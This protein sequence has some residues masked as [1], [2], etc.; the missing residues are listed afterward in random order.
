[1]SYQ[2]QD[3][4]LV[5]AL[6]LTQQIKEAAERADVAA[7]TALDGQRAKLIHSFRR[8]MRSVNEADRALLRQITELNDR[9]IGMLEHHQRSKGRELDLAA[10]GRRAVAAYA[11]ARGR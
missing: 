6:R 11:Q 2:G 3:A 8:A 10:V 1:M 7:V 9:A 5:H 4:G